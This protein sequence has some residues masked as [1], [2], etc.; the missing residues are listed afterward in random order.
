MSEDEK[1]QSGG[2]TYN[3][4]KGELGG[5]AEAFLSNLVDL[6]DRTDPADG[7]SSEI[8]K[9]LAAFDALIL[10]GNLVQTTA[11]WA[12]DHQVGL[13]L[14]GLDFVPLAGSKTRGLP[15]YIEARKKVDSHRHE[16]AGTEIGSPFTSPPGRKLTTDQRRAVA[17]SLLRANVG[18]FPDGIAEELC[19][20]LEALAFGKVAPILQPVKGWRKAGL[21]RKREQLNAVCFALFRSGTGMKAGDAWQQIA[22][23]YS[24]DRETLQGWRKD[25]R[26]EFG[27]I[28]VSRQEEYATNAASHIAE[29]RNSQPA[30]AFDMLQNHPRFGNA[31]LLR[32]VERFKVA[33]QTEPAKARGTRRKLK[34]ARAS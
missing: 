14:E 33:V 31:E 32:S 28:H 34:A 15:D 24:V 4:A 20:A 17:I 12:I 27:I 29:I 9:D 7:A 30:E 18:G 5:A 1:A 16:I 21:L 6:R 22:Q 23:A 3:Y 8:R 19:E 2:R 26:K 10:A 13:A 25:A 11:Q